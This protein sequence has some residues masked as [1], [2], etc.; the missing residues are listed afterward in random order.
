MKVGMKI[1]SMYFASLAG[2]EEEGSGK[3]EES[4]VLCRT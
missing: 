2:T 1:A 4:V 3:Y